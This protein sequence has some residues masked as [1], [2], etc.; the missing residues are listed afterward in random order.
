MSL[1]NLLQLFF[2]AALIW[3]AA[4]WLVEASDKIAKITGLGHLFV[5]SFFLA[6]STSA[7]EFFVDIE[8]TQKGI[9]DL[10]AGDLLGS[11]LVNLTILCVLSLI[12]WKSVNCQLSRQ[13]RLS[14]W[15][16]ALLTAEVGFFIFLG[17][18]LSFREF[19]LSSLVL[20]ITYLVGL[21]AIFEKPQVNNEGKSG[22]K[23]V[24]ARLLLK[25][26]IVFF[27]GTIL[28]FFASP[29][30]VSSAEKIAD[31]T[32]LGKTL[33][34]TSL[35][36]FTT[37]FP[38]LFSSITAIRKGLFQLV[39]GNIVGSNCINVLIFVVMNYSIWKDGSLWEHISRKNLITASFVVMNMVFLAI[40]WGIKSRQ[41][42][43]GNRIRVWLILL[44]SVSCYVILYFLREMSF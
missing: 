29:Y 10:A 9:P 20:V 35:L 32:G 40:P 17:S 27:S 38:E 42:L 14:S 43:I 36:A 15:L 12:F 28:I 4:R 7:P 26:V 18:D 21:R 13:T 41:H 3:L 5:G 1:E 22:E 39:A 33:I 16:A 34:G 19:S 44:L 6:A 11:S 24:K 23:L 37:S 2:S 8:A 31:E 30:L 25:P